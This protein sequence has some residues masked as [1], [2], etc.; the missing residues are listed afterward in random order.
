MSYGLFNYYYNYF[1]VEPDFIKLDE[2]KLSFF[3]KK[4]EPKQI[5]VRETDEEIWKR[6]NAH[7]DLHNLV[8]I[9]FEAIYS[10]KIITGGDVCRRER[11]SN[12]SVVG[13][14]IFYK[15]L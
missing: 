5:K 13:Y 2:K 4:K 14:R 7:I 10:C 12:E 6:I 11:V 3:S 15:E 8:V 9:N 1:D